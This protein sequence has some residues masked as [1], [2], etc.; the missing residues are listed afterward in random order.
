M[1]SR[2]LDPRTYVVHGSGDTWADVTEASAGSPSWVRLRYEWPHPGLVHW[3]LLDSDHCRAGTGDV[4]I[5]P[6]ERGTRVE[7]EINHSG[8]R[9]VR[10][11][12]ILL[13]QRLLAPI[14]FPR[15]WKAALDRL[16]ASA[17]GRA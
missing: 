8:P 15:W 12:L 5:V 4:R 7:V 3:T 13:V 9:G 2:T 11:A 10:G 1:W 17:S 16:A 14:A 6:G